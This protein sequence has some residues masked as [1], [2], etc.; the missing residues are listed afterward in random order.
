RLAGAG[1]LRQPHDGAELEVP[2]DLGGDLG[3][4]VLR[5][6]RRD[7]AAHVA[8]GGRLTLDRF[9]FDS[10]LRCGL[11]LCWLVFRG[12]AVGRLAVGGFGFL[13][14]RLKSRSWFQRAENRSAGGAISVTRSRTSRLLESGASVIS[15]GSSRAVQA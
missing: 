3:E 1:S 6:Q 11:A 15:R 8:E 14:H 10:F 7:P 9:A 13:Q 2:I 4:L 12:L 5:L